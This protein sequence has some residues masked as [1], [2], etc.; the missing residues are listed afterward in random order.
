MDSADVFFV[1]S[2]GIIVH[3]ISSK[4][5]RDQHECRRIKNSHVFGRGR[6]HNKDNLQSLSRKDLA[7]KSDLIMKYRPSNTIFIRSMSTKRMCWIEAI[8]FRAPTNGFDERLVPF[9][10]LGQMPSLSLFI[11]SMYTYAHSENC[12]TSKWTKTYLRNILS[13]LHHNTGG[14]CM[15]M[16][17]KRSEDGWFVEKRKKKERKKEK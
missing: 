4:I 7:Q 15:E 13:I 12:L 3:S 16:R 9:F 14:P 5:T 2:S 11:N 10:F 6:L 8:E 1:F 17:R